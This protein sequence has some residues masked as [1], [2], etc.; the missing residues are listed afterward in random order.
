MSHLQSLKVVTSK[1]PARLS[2]IQHRRNK[3]ID[4]LHEQ[5]EC[6]KA[7]IDGRDLVL[8][9][10]RNVKNSETGQRFQME[11]QYRVKPWWFTDDAGKTIFEV[12]YGSRVIEVAKGKT[13]I[14]VDSLSDLPGVIELMKKAVDAGELDAGI[15]ALAG[16]FGR[17]ILNK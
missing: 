13:G 8:T 1:R 2:P 4:K 15:T 17:Q 6:A 14:E 9:R 10:Q 16:V 5:L 3:L 11:Q 12:R 7:R